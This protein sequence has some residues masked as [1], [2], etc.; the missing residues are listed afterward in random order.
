MVTSIRRIGF[1]ALIVSVLLATLSAR[2]QNQ[3]SSGTVP[4]TT[5]VTALGPKYT[6][7]PPISQSDVSV[8]SGKDKQERNLRGVLG[9]GR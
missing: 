3:T 9:A 7:P 1:L 8:Y 6:A 2:A 5:V 4:I